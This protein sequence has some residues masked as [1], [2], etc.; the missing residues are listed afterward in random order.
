MSNP[1]FY[2]NQALGL[3]NYNNSRTIY[4]GEDSDQYI[5]ISRGAFNALQDKCTKGNIELIIE[6]LRCKGNHINVSFN[7]TLKENQNDALDSLLSVDNGILNA[8]T[9]F[10]KTVVCC[11]LIAQLKTS[12]LILVQQTTVLPNAVAAYNIPFM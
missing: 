6:D 11:Y 8:A 12:T 10:G 7:G 5:H 4:L 1:N 2:K 9:A 3:S